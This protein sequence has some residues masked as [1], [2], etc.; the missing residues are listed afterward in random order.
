MIHSAHCSLTGSCWLRP[1]KGR[2]QNGWKVYPLTG[3]SSTLGDRERV[4]C[5]ETW[6]HMESKMIW[7]MPA[8]SALSMNATSLSLLS[9]SLHAF[10]LLLKPTQW[11]LKRSCEIKG[12]KFPGWWNNFLWRKK[13]RLE[14]QWELPDREPTLV[15]TNLQERCLDVWDTPVEMA[16][17]KYY[18]IL[19]I[20][21]V[22]V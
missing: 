16:N 20:M 22:W 1:V 3:L 19:Y 15:W 9:K 18:H 2:A 11:T 4:Q 13:T 21:I 7:S 12:V 5:S 14:S 10:C 8:S 17:I 6:L